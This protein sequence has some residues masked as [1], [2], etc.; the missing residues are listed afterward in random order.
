MRIIDNIHR[1]L[2]DDLKDTLT[3]GARLK[4]AASTFSIFAIDALKAELEKTSPDT[5]LRD[6]TG[7]AKLGSLGSDAGERRNTSYSFAL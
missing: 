5:A 7:L 3:K 4:V 2:G 6:V 1:L